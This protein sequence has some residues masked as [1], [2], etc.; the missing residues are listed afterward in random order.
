MNPEPKRRKDSVVTIF[1]KSGLFF[2]DCFEEPVF[3][4]DR[5]S[6]SQQRRQ[7]KSRAKK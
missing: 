5:V 3:P 2:G 7:T 4:E 6:E 1:G